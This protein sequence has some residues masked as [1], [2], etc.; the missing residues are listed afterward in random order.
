MR[1]GPAVIVIVASCAPAPEIGHA[2]APSRARPEPAAPLPPAGLGAPW[3]LA[4]EWTGPGIPPK[5]FSLFD[6]PARSP[7]LAYAA[8][9]RDA[10]EAE[11]RRRGVAFARA[12]DA[13]GV[14]D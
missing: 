9:D 10:C 2:P 5:Q 12:D 13:P 8:H 3:A 1:W 7:V 4:S 11:L 14:R 6:I